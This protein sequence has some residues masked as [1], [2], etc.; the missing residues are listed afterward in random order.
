MNS[1]LD[2]VI[3][4]LN[5]LFV[6]MQKHDIELYNHIRSGLPELQPFFAISWILTW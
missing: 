2:V 6:L 1:G 4:E 5:L 3:Q